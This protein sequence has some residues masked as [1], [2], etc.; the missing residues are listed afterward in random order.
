MWQIWL[1]IALFFFILEIATTGFLVFWFGIGA[2]VAMLFSLLGIHLVLQ[3]IIFLIVSTIL[4]IFTKPLVNKLAKPESNVKTNVYSIEGKIG[5]VTKDIEPVDGKGQVI[6]DGES[7][8]AKS[9]DNSFIPKGTEII[10]ESLN[11]VKV[12]VKPYNFNDKN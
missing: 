7:W 4:I 8:S 9:Y 1:I 6:V 11:G 3:I 10:V 5:K 12:I 2:L